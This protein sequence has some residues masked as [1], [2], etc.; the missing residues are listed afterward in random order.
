MQT[1]HMYMLSFIPVSRKLLYPSVVPRSTRERSGTLL[2]QLS[3]LV[4]SVSLNRKVMLP[5]S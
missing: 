3:A 1:V 5:P 4:G 2:L